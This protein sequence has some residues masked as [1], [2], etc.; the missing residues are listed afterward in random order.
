M[1]CS[2]Q[3]YLAMEPCSA[4]PNDART[5]VR[6]RVFAGRLHQLAV[7]EDLELQV[8]AVEERRSYLVFR[9]EF[10]EVYFEAQCKLFGGVLAAR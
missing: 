8:F 5:L 3:T 9:V 7:D 2:E 6:A 4:V 1:R 10:D